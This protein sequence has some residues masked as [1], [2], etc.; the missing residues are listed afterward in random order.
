MNRP[1]SKMAQQL[2]INWR[3]MRMGMFLDLV[4]HNS[5]MT[6]KTSITIP[7]LRANTKTQ[8]FPNL[9]QTAHCPKQAKNSPLF[10]DY[11]L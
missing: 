8:N 6:H 1:Y 4:K 11:H 10:F 2:T 5:S 9:N 7:T 3:R